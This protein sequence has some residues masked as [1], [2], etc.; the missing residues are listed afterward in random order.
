MTKGDL[1]HVW[2]LIGCKNHWIRH[3]YD[4]PFTERSFREC[5]TEDELIA[6]L[7]H[8]NWCLGQAFYLRNLC[9]IQQVEGGDEWLVI[10][11]DVPFESISAEHVLSRE[12]GEEKF[13]GY[14]EQFF[15]A[16][17]EQLRSLN[18]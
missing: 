5:A 9:F 10:R 6:Q 8:G 1:V 7:R 3:A 18:Y 12:G 14:L 11:G 16:T 4:P 2:L 17:D 15:K 13:R